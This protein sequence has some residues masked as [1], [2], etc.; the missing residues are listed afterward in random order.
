M[1][2]DSQ[3]IK[4][5]LMVFLC[6]M[7]AFT[8]APVSLMMA[9]AASTDVTHTPQATELS[10][11]TIDEDNTTMSG[12]GDSA[13]V[14]GDGNGTTVPDDEDGGTVPDDDNTTV[15][16]NEDGATALGDGDGTVSGD[17]DATVPADDT[18][19][20]D[21][22]DDVTVPG[23]DDTT[24]PGDGTTVPDN[25]NGTAV[26]GNN[27]M[28]APGDEDD[29]IV[30]GDEDGTTPPGNGDDTIVPDDREDTTVLGDGEDTTV[31]G[32]EDDTTV[33]DGEDD[34][35]GI[36]QLDVSDIVLTVE[37]PRFA[38]SFSYD[39]LAYRFS[40]E[41]DIFLRI[42]NNADCAISVICVPEL[43]EETKALY[44]EIGITISEEPVEFQLDAGAQKEI[45]IQ[46]DDF[47]GA[48]I[49]R[50]MFERLLADGNAL[51]F[52][53]ALSCTPLEDEAVEEDGLQAN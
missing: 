25:E 35:S 29:M 1:K 23:N 2:C 16:D 18:I 30:P 13:A 43:S 11:D 42:Q 21:N 3:F 28:S 12:D 20:P 49:S 4:R 38:I 14:P 32:D 26:P 50:S 45:M 10:C 37:Q 52:S 44:H 6:G 40:I 47:E 19:A 5:V 31:L 15:P 36:Y 39:T 48:D 33:P 53:A 41:S 22:E 8:S 9:K 27:D 51:A 46:F 7:L 24:V 17:D 34:E